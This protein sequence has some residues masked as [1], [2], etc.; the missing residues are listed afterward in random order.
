MWEEGTFP[1]SLLLTFRKTTGMPVWQGFHQEA[2][3]PTTNHPHFSF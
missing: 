3:T 2:L 1:A